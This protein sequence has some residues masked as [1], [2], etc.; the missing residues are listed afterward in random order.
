MVYSARFFVPVSPESIDESQSPFIMQFSP[1]KAILMKT[2]SDVD[3]LFG[4]RVFEGPRKLQDLV[5][6]RQ[7]MCLVGFRRTMAAQLGVNG[8]DRT[9]RRAFHTAEPLHASRSLGLPTQV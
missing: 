2:M 6:G 4:C 9:E 1:F 8:F 5:S 3:V 7:G